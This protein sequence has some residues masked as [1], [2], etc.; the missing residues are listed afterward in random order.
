MSVDVLQLAREVIECDR[1]AGAVQSLEST[2]AAEVIRLRDELD[3]LQA[4]LEAT[5]FSHDAMIALEGKL[6]AM[7]KARDC[8]CAFM[9]E[10][11]DLIEF[12]DKGDAEDWHFQ[13]ARLQAVG[14]ESR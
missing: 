1:R 10:A 14:K 6:A 12:G 11:L 9:N 2:L 5:E 8:A 13:L 3:V 7:T 4:K